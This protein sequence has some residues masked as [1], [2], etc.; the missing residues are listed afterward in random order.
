MLAFMSGFPLTVKFLVEAM[1]VNILLA[2][3][4]VFTSIILLGALV[5][6]ALGFFKQFFILLYGVKTSDKVINP[7]ISKRDTTI[8]YFITLSLIALNFLT[9]LI[10]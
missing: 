4:Y 1:L 8:F 10:Y 3:S 5:F 6:G 7:A 2:N 9:F